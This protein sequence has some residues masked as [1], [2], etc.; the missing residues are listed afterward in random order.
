MGL[1]IPYHNDLNVG[2]IPFDPQTA[3]KG[4][5]TSYLK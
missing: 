2:F 3:S 1:T 5:Q 4:V